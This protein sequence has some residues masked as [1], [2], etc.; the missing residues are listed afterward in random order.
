MSGA[1]DVAVDAL[2]ALLWEFPAE[3]SLPRN[4]AHRSREQFSV[5]K[6]SN[7]DKVHDALWTLQEY[8]GVNQP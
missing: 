8:L 7:V 3:F 2:K 1:N 5:I 4:G 6:E